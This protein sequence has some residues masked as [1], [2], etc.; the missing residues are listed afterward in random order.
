MFDLDFNVTNAAPVKQT[1]FVINKIVRFKVQDIL[2]YEVWTSICREG[3]TAVRNTTC[4]ISKLLQLISAGYTIIPCK[5]SPKFCQQ[6][7]LL[8]YDYS[9][10]H[11]IKPTAFNK[12]IIPTFFINYEQPHY[13]GV[14]GTKKKAILGYCFNEPIRDRKSVV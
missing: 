2:N 14:S 10:E 8:G 9:Y 7:L 12:N 4:T 1:V 11:K 6:I 5:T 3:K 13:Y